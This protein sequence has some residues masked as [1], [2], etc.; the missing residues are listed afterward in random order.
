MLALS[1]ALWL[2]VANWLELCVALAVSVA[3]GDC[4]S[5]AVTEMLCEALRVSVA[6][7]VALTLAVPER[8]G[9][10]EALEDPEG[11]TEAEGDWLAV[12]VAE[13]EGAQIFLMAVRRTAR[14]P[15]ALTHE[16]PALAL[17]QAARKVAWLPDDAGAAPAPTLNQSTGA[18][19]DKTT[20]Y[21]V[22]SALD[23]SRTS[24]ESGSF[25]YAAGGAGGT[26]T[27]TSCCMA[28]LNVGAAVA[29]LT[30][31]SRTWTSMDALPPAACA[32][33]SPS[34]ES[35]QRPGPHM[36][37]FSITEKD[38]AAH[39]VPLRVS[40]APGSAGRLSAP[41]LSR[42]AGPRSETL[43]VIDCVC[44]CVWLEDCVRLCDWLGVPLCVCDADCVLLGLCVSV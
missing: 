33:A 17:S 40:A 29:L 18:D 20:A 38:R 2:A 16:A 23:V 39:A 7:A 35:D 30:L 31:Y 15:A 1:D 21:C 27:P 36:G 32:R 34:S 44:V 22:P 12:V 24:E 13:G 5:L 42:N 14:V 3:L 28:K 25:V 4:V 41:V 9:V 11:V 6:L 8:L 26:A 43:G 10:C 19:A 37:S